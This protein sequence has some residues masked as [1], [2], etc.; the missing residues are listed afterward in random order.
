M[1]D[2]QPMQ[3]H[4]VVHGRVQ[5]VSFRAYTQDKAVELGL[6]GWVRNHADGTVEVLAEG[7]RKQLDALLAFLQIGPLPARVTNVEV[8]WRRAVGLEAG[9]SIV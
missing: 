9:F 4:A 3:L 7:S 1:T 2:D 8:T 5:G 6:N